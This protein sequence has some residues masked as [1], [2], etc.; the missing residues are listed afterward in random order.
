MIYAC[1]IILNYCCPFTNYFSIFSSAQTTIVI[2]THFMFQICFCYQ[3]SSWYLSLFCLLSVPQFFFQFPTRSRYLSFFSLSFIFTLWSVGT[4]KSTI[5]KLL[6]FVDYYKVWSSSRDLVIRLH[7]KNPEEFVRLIFQDMLVCA[8]NNCFYG[9]IPVSCI[10]P[11][12]LPCL[13]SH[14]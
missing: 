14:S 13:P 7:F 10:I 1:P 8:Y 9:Q 6:F 2:H 5:I 4:A 11:I 12:G 3:T